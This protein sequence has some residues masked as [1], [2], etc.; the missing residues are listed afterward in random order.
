MAWRH[1]TIKYIT[2]LEPVSLV[3]RET[4]HVRA[5][6]VESSGKYWQQWSFLGSCLLSLTMFSDV[7]LVA[8]VLLENPHK[9]NTWAKRRLWRKPATR[10]MALFSEKKRKTY[11]SMCNKLSPFS[12]I[13]TSSFPSAISSSKKCYTAS[14]LLGLTSL[15]ALLAVY[16]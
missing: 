1:E 15:T 5:P 8:S 11:Y 7:C 10:K 16:C 3:R 4:T 6:Y 14:Q 12:G 2:I 9:R 13:Y